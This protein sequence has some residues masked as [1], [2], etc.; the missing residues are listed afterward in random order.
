[1]RV[2]ACME[3]RFDEPLTPVSSGYKPSLKTFAEILAYTLSRSRRQNFG[4]QTICETGF[5]TRS[6]QAVIRFRLRFCE[7]ASY[8]H[9]SGG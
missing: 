6:F 7:V 8:S 9:A 1:M 3:G 2:H 5:S 4:V